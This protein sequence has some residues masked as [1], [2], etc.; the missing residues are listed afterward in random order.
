MFAEP[1][2]TPLSGQANIGQCNTELKTLTADV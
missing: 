2:R 1:P